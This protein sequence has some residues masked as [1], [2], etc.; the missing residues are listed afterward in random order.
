MRRSS[1]VLPL[2]LVPYAS[3][4]AWLGEFAVRTLDGFNAGTL[5]QISIPP[6][7]EDV[8]GEDGATATLRNH[9]RINQPSEASDWFAYRVRHMRRPLTGGI[10]SG[11]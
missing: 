11:H 6:M 10:T 5:A 8:C 2:V 7:T 9:L 1:L 3:E 4:S